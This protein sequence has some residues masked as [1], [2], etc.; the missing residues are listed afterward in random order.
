VDFFG[1]PWEKLYIKNERKNLA[2]KRGTDVPN[3]MVI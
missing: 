3:N 1:Y 2:K